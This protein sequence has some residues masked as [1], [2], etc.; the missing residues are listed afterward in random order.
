M[1]R[2]FRLC[3]QKFQ[4]GIEKHALFGVL[5]GARLFATVHTPLVTLAS[6][7]EHD[8]PA[9]RF[10]GHHTAMSVRSFRSVG[11]KARFK[12]AWL[13]CARLDFDLCDISHELILFEWLE[14]AANDGKL[15]VWRL[16]K[17]MDHD[18]WLPSFRETAGFQTA[19]GSAQQ[20][21]R[22]WLGYS[23]F[24]CLEGKYIRECRWCTCT[25]CTWKAGWRRWCVV[26]NVCIFEQI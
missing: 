5:A 12:D 15:P 19:A 4:Q 10:V 3:I 14:C 24:C 13:Q 22:L 11:D 17:Q 21:W 25:A 20:E 18:Y 26:N 7:H 1:L 8:K 6:V 9:M 2:S 23:T 16:L